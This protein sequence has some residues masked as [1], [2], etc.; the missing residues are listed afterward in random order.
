MK[1]RD[2]IPPPTEN[3][4]ETPCP[5]VPVVPLIVKL[6]FLPGLY[7]ESVFLAPDIQRQ[8]PHEAKLFSIVD[9]Q[10]KE[11]MRKANKARFLAFST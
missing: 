10:W 7:L 11:I 9:K 6:S 3:W 8:L 2:N 1:K 4:L 5:N